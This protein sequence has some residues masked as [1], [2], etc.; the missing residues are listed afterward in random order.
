ML[1]ADSGANNPI[2][3]NDA[4]VAT[5]TRETITLSVLPASGEKDKTNFAL[6]ATLSA[7]SDF[8][9]YTVTVD[10]F[11]KDVEISGTAAQTIWSGT[12]SEAKTIKKADIHVTVVEKVTAKSAEVKDSTIIVKFNEEMEEVKATTT[13]T[14]L[15]ITKVETVG[16]TTTITVAGAAADSDV[17]TLT[18]HQ[19]GDKNNRLTVGAGDTLTATVSAGTT[20]WAV[21]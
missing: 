5:A 8:Y 13:S 4:G 7:D 17:I 12:L 16:D 19:K 1:D 14:T 15:A 2:N 20:T 11:C 3:L 10:G 9:K 18:G 6:Q 21:S